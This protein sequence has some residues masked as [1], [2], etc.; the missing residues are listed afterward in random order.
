MEAGDDK[1]NPAERKIYRGRTACENIYGG[2]SHE[3]TGK[4][5]RDR[6]AVLCGEQ[7]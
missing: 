3:K 7:P 4:E 2:F 1:E 5:Q 6:T